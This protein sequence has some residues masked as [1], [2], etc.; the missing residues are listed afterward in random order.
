[1]NISIPGVEKRLQTRYAKLVEEHLGHGHSVA[2]GPRILP[3]KNAT[4]AAAMAAWRF[5]QNSCT[6]FPV[7]AQPLIEAARDSAARYC[8]DFALIDI[9]WCWLDYGHHAS[10]AD[11][12]K[13]PYGGLGYKLLS[14]LLISDQDG[15]PL[16][17]LCEQLL[18]SRNLLSS[19]LRR[20]LPART[21]LDE[22]A[23]VMGFVHDLSLGKRPVFIIDEEADS[24][25][26][27]R[28]WQ[29]RNFLFLVRVDDDRHVRVDGKEML[30][31][32]VVRR[33][34]QQKAFHLS[35]EVDYE[36]KKVWQ[37]V[38]ETAVVVDRAAWLNRDVNG[39]RHRFKIR[40]KPLKVRL[41][42]TELRDQRGRLL[43]RWYLLTN[44]PA[45]VDAATIASWY[46]WRWKIETFHKLLKSAGQQVEH[47]QQEDPKALLKRLLVASMACVLAW[48]LAVSQAPQAD[49]ARRVIMSLSGRQLEYGK[50]YTLEGLLAGIWVLLAMMALLQSMPASRLKEI[51]DFVLAGS[52]APTRGPPLP[53]R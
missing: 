23:A 53:L 37:Y 15:Q 40:G 45:E 4:Q 18:T 8:R 17:P 51:A 2:A 14:A 7:L 38:A 33:L 9:D 20:P 31:P 1:M 52:T 3:S 43:H 36:G 22:L 5:Y 48:R 44:V 28:W 26:H 41:I 32:A 19:R 10:K 29:R 24:V 35:R 42:V 47:W 39:Q 49:E 21:A 46:Y 30:L 6:S 11:R 27:L 12:R 13:G 34:Q 50:K 16:T 25:Y